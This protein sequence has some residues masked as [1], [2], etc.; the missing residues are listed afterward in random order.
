MTQ[1]QEMF[2][3]WNSE[4]L[5]ISVEESRKRY[6]ASAAVF[7]G[8]HTGSAFGK[9]NGAAHALLQ[10][11]FDDSRDEVFEIYRVHGLLHFLSFLTYPEPNWSVTDLIVRE[12]SAKTAVSILDFGCGLAQQSRTLAEYL[13]NRGVSVRL[14]LADIESLRADFLLW[15]GRRS[16]IETSFL[17]CTR[18]S[19][20]P[21]LPEI[22][23]CFATEFFEHVHNPLDYFERFDA[24][25]ASGG[26]LLT[27]IMDHHEGFMHVSPN[28][29]KLRDR[30][31]ERGY[32]VLV[33]DRILKKP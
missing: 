24:K 2:I 7:P 20:I 14:V 19:P 25:L 10:V 18:P 30:I 1:T 3:I 23:V 29:A 17:A 31:E 13:Q 16:G 4:R 28:L 11:F 15:W 22:D 8:G 6:F 26:L 5:G 33:A 21:D 9:F 32:R 27:G 12:L